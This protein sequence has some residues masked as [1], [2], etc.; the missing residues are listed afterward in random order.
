MNIFLL[1]FILFPLFE[2]AGFVVIGGEIGLGNTLLWLMASAGLGIWVLRGQGDVWAR[3]QTVDDDL[4]V[5]E[6]MF[7]ALCMLAAG[8]LLLFPGFISDFIA[9]PLLVPPLRR[10]IFRH[11]QKRPDG[12][13]RR[14]AR[15]SHTTRHG[16]TGAET[17]VIEAEY[18]EIDPPPPSSDAPRLPPQ[19]S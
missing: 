4:F 16:S 6:G 10:L 19:N 1:L 17:T 8:L 2:I 3:V 7:D 14:H 12:F 5:I 11:I 13:I 15:F 18:S 9:L